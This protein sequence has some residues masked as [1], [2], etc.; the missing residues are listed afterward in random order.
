MAQGSSPKEG[1]T[2]DKQEG[3]LAYSCQPGQ[4]P[5]P[6]VVIDSTGEYTTAFFSTNILSNYILNTYPWFNE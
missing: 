3:I 2:Q 6:G 5:M 1:D 4:Q